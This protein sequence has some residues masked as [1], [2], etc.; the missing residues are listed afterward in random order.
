MGKPDI[1]GIFLTTD[2]L[3]L[4]LDKGSGIGFYEIRKK[5]EILCSPRTCVSRRCSK[6]CQT[7]IG[8]IWTCQQFVQAQVYHTPFGCST[9][10]G[11]R[12]KAA[13]NI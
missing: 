13:V 4:N 12:N 5:L 11:L 9:M 7:K 8:G 2:F 3:S 6:S 10:I 1:V